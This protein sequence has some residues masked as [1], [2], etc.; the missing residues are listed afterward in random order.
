MEPTTEDLSVFNA[1]ISPIR[2]LSEDEEEVSTKLKDSSEEEERP[3]KNVVTEKDFAKL[4]KKARKLG[5]ESLDF[6]PRKNNRYV[7]TLQMDRKF[8]LVPPN[9][10]IFLSIKLMLEKRDILREQ[11]KLK[12]KGVNFS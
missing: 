9:I 11:R 2:Y 5:A 12:T 6:S 10:Q 8:I 3:A 7:A 4:T 1:E